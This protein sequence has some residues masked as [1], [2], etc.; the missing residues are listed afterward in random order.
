MSKIAF[1]FP[2]QGTQY[3][4]MGKKLYESMD[5]ENKKMIDDIF[6]A[7]GD[8]KVKEVVLNGTE[9]ELKNTRFAQPAIALLSVVLTKLL[10]ERGLKA[11]F[12]AGHS[13]GEYSAL[14]ALGILNEKD[15]LKLI[16]ERGKIM[17]EAQIDGFMAAILGLSSSDVEIIALE[18]DGI[19]EAVN[20]NEPKQTVIAGEKDAVEKSLDIFKE[21]GAKRAM[22][23]AVSGPFHSSLMKPV[24]KILEKEFEKYKWNDPEIPVI[25]NI[26][27]MILSNANK[28]KEELYKQT[29]GPVKWVD[30]INVLAEN[31]VTKIYEI[32]PGKV[33]AGLIRK[34]N[35]ELEVVNI[36]NVENIESL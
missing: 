12:V 27:T 18:I 5:K 15:T 10:K 3:A 6:L 2:G 34:I 9:E 29:F 35:K 21:K 26:N 24:A 7:I 17:S 14:Y 16:S 32:G 4:E 23:L 30:T 31:G 13:L 28:I 1:V 33:L 8:E 19:I 11:D 20:Y 25:A 22:P 36:E